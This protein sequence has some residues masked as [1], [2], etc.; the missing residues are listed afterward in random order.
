MGWAGLDQR[1]FPRYSARCDI[2][3]SD[4]GETL[5]SKTQNVGVGGVCVLLNKELQKLSQVK[6][7]LVM[8]ESMR[9]IE[10]E[11]RIVWMIPSKE[12]ASPKKHYDTGIEFLNLDPKDRDRIEV[13]VRRLVVKHG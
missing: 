13:F 1:E 2:T 10:C 3:I 9:P 11:G 5:K 7:H 12:L 6:L 4:G 8:D